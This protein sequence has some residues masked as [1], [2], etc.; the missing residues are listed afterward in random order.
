MFCL[1]YFKKILLDRKDNEITIFSH[2]L[3]IHQLS[4]CLS[5]LLLTLWMLQKGPP[6]GAFCIVCRL[7]LAVGFDLPFLR[8][9][10]YPRLKSLSPN[11]RTLRILAN[12]KAFCIFHWCLS[13]IHSEFQCDSQVKC[14]LSFEELKL[15]F[16]S[17]KF[18]R[19][20][21]I[22]LR[23][24]IYTQNSLTCVLQTLMTRSFSLKVLVKYTLFTCS[25]RL[26]TTK[27]KK[28]FILLLFQ[29]FLNIK[30][31]AYTFIYSFI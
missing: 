23:I 13:F 24:N 1:F 14:C 29:I 8:F 20:V 11:F 15:S 9:C 3:T 21:F 6:Y 25:P 10:Y 4:Q 28:Q 30:L 16:V 31:S 12:Q 2:L 18:P 7:L 17:I 26:V 5:L 27:F 19:P 22:K